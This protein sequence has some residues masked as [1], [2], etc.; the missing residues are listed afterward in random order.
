M[1]GSK[2]LK[3]HGDHS[4]TDNLIDLVKQLPLKEQEHLLGTISKWIKDNREC[5]RVDCHIEV[6]YSDNN[7]LAHGLAKNISAKG[8]YLD[9]A[10]P[11]P[12]GQDIIIS[13][14]HP[15]GGEHIKIRGK[16]VRRDERGMAIAFEDCVERI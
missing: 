2:K 3:A 9:P 12:V 5:P 7:R 15:S 13:M 14:P 1:E 10:G 11:F 8:I 4:I 6:L 16:I